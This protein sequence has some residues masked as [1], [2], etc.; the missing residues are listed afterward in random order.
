MENSKNTHIHT[1]RDAEMNLQTDVVNIHMAIITAF[2]LTRLFCV[3]EFY[4]FQIK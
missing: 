1:T 4:N 3:S 2:L